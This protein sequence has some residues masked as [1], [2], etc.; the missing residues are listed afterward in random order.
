MQMAA[1]TLRT[2][3]IELLRAIV[4]GHD[5]E[6][7]IEM[8]LIELRNHLDKAGLDIQAVVR[9]VLQDLNSILT[10]AEMSIRESDDPDREIEHILLASFQVAAEKL[11]LDDAARGRTSQR[12][13]RLNDRIEARLRGLEERS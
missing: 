7:R 1:Q 6:E 12:M 11:S 5:T 2:L 3:T 10:T 13:C 4:R 8:Q 9:I